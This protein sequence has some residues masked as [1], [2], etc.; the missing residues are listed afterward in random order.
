M[1]RGNLFYGLFLRTNSPFGSNLRVPNNPLNI[2][3]LTWHCYLHSGVTCPAQFNI[4]CSLALRLL[5]II[6]IIIIII[7]NIYRSAK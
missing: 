1:A 4:E 3:I 6:I 2:L 7:N 5:I